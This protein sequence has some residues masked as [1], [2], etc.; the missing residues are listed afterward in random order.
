MKKIIL[1]L[2]FL[3][4]SLKGMSQFYII[5]SVV[6]SLTGLPISNV[7]VTLFNNDT[8]FF[9]EERTAAAGN[10]VFNNIPANTY[11][12]GAE[13]IGEEYRQI[14][15]NLIRD[16]VLAYQFQ[17]PP[18]TQK[19]QWNVIVQSPEPLGLK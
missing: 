3:I 12:I 16:T 4:L 1:L 10:F 5:G 6:D 14:T 17:L 18:E 8:T 19:G 2:A 13:Y 11:S 9:R 7:R 15:L